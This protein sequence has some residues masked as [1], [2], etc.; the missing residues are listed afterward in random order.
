VI[1]GE[2]GSVARLTRYPVKSMGGEDLAVATVVSRGLVGDRQWAVRT[3]DGGVGS[4]KTTRRFRR[5]D[6]LLEFRATQPDGVPVVVFPDR[7]RLRADDPA[8]DEQLSAELGRPVALRP[9]GDVPHHDESPLHVI[10]TSG[11]ER[12]GRTLGAPVDPARFR[13]N[14]VLET[15]GDEG[16][17]TGRDLELGPDVVLRLGPGMIRCVMV[18]LAQRDVPRDGRILKTLADGHDLVFGL[19]AT[20]VRGGTVRRGDTARLL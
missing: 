9:E 2:A 13:A 10:T 14:V 18:D 4:G 5:I 16:D 19:Q 6:G 20:V 3:P 11:L 7:R 8:V 12:L 1:A 17:W 15:D